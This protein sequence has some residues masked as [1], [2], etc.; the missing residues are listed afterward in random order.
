ML[1]MNAGVKLPTLDEQIAEH[2]KALE[3]AGVE[4]QCAAP[5]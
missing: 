2:L 3:A 5:A 1:F 4:I